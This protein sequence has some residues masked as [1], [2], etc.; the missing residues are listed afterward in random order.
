MAQTRPSQSFIWPA[1]AEIELLGV[2]YCGNISAT[3]ASLCIYS[4]PRCV[5]VCLCQCLC[6]ENQS[7]VGPE[8]RCRYVLKAIHIYIRYTVGISLCVSVFMCERLTA[9]RC[10]WLRCQ[11]LCPFF[12]FFLSLPTHTH[13][14][15]QI[16]SCVS[17]FV[18]SNSIDAQIFM[19]GK[20]G[21]RGRQPKK[22]RAKKERRGKCCAPS[23][24]PSHPPL[25][26]NTRHP[27]NHPKTNPPDKVLHPLTP[28]HKPN[29][30]EPKLKPIQFGI[31]RMGSFFFGSFEPPSPYFTLGKGP[32]LLSTCCPFLSWHP[33]SKTEALASQKKKKI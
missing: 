23:Q 22:K 21:K 14:H 33:N 29:R 32:L 17:G 31:A 24:S 4:V 30:T 18:Q 19:C 6:G 25:A 27:S 9:F 15:T 1:L 11:Q 8:R 3:P 16:Q 7:Q 5:C 12:P 26:A 20:K 10:R 2:N 13:T 28:P